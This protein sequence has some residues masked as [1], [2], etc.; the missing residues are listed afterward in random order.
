MPEFPTCEGLQEQHFEAILHIGTMLSTLSH[1]ERLV[2]VVDQ[3]IED[4]M[5]GVQFTMTLYSFTTSGVILS[6]WMV[7]GR[8]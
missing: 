5:V 7:S 4:S 2:G 8:S 1:K 3:V 6:Y